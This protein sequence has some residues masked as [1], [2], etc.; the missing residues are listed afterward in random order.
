MYY[1]TIILKSAILEEGDALLVLYEII[2]EEDR[3]KRWGIMKI[4][5]ENEKYVHEIIP[6]YNGTQEH[7]WLIDTENHFTSI[8]DEVKWHP[9]YDSQGREFKD[10][11]MPL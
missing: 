5:F 3:D 4:T 9:L 1:G 11:Y 7:Y 6:N 8:I 10:D 2:R